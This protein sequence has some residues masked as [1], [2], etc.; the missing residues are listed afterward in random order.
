MIEIKKVNNLQRWK[1][2]AYT[3][4]HMFTYACIYVGEYREQQ[5]KN[6]KKSGKWKNKNPKKGQFCNQILFFLLFWP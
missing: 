3:Q 5:K 2:T 6:R 4:P 1:L